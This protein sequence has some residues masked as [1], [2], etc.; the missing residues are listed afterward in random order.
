M[1]EYHAST[2]DTVWGYYGLTPE[3]AQVGGMNPQMFNSFS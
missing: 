3:Q 2:P 1:P